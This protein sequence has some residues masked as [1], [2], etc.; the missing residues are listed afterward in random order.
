MVFALDYKI[1]F[2]A[3]QYFAAKFPYQDICGGSAIAEMHSNTT[4]FMVICQLPNISTTIYAMVLQPPNSRTICD[5][6]TQTL[7]PVSNLNYD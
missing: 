2:P 4:K 6:R 5:R 3:P 1:R 7:I